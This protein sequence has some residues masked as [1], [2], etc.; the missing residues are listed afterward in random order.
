MRMWREGGC[1]AMAEE[2]SHTNDQIS[3][4]ETFAQDPTSSGRSKRAHH[5]STASNFLSSSRDASAWWSYEQPMLFH[6]RFFLT[7]FGVA[8]NICSE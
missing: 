5:D 1:N 3:G 2:K 6:I 7:G 4:C 8:Q